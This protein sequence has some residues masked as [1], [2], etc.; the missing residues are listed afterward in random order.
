MRRLID[1]IERAI[2]RGYEFANNVCYYYFERKHRFSISV[3]MARR[4]V[5]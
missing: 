3:D 2:V 4:T 1:R 5:P